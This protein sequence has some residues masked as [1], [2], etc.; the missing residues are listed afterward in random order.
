M[1]ACLAILQAPNPSSKTIAVIYFTMLPKSELRFVKSL[2]D[3]KNRYSE[4]LFVTEGKKLTGDLIM[5]GLV[6]TKLY[7]LGNE[8]LE[9]F[10][11]LVEFESLEVSKSEME[12]MSNLQSS[13]EMLA[14]F[15]FRSLPK[16][17]SPKTGLM[18]VLDTIQDPGNL[19][20]IIRL[21]DWYGVKTI[22]CSPET[23]DLYNQKVI[24]STM[25]SLA[26]VDVYYQDLEAFFKGNSLPVFG[27]MMQGEKPSKFKWNGPSILLIGNEGKG[28]SKNLESY[29][30][31]RLSIP[32]IGQAESLNAA[33]ATG[34]LLDNLLNQ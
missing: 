27:A 11:R 33:I 4:R 5:A 12:Q 22:V 9:D 6:P 21:A 2:K 16:F 14:I 1:L 34:I 28:I 15:P 29:L 17:E 10:Y 13:R 24:Q 31:N 20:T 7:H 32:R 18:L 3:K 19:G 30:S 8:N 26:R 23:A 25:G